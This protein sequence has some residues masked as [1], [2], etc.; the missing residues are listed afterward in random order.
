M[1]PKKTRTLSK[2]LTGHRGKSF[3]CRPIV[4]KVR[5]FFFSNKTG[6]SHTC[7]GGKLSQV[8]QI[9]K[10][11]F[12]FSFTDLWTEFLC[13]K[14]TIYVFTGS[15]ATVCFSFSSVGDTSFRSFYR[16]FTSPPHVNEFRSDRWILT[17]TLRFFGHFAD[18]RFVEWNLF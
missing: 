17:S 12:S 6:K 11:F 7:S 10:L 14:L 15:H 3:Y 8:K 4:V 5:E 16:F 2:W 1:G 13:W 18:E 9:R